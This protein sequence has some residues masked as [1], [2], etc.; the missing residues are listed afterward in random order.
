MLYINTL[1]RIVSGLLLVSH[2]L[3]AEE[4]PNSY[5]SWLENVNIRPIGTLP[6][7]P[8]YTDYLTALASNNPELKGLYH[9]WKSAKETVTI[10]GAWSDP[11]IK[12]GAALLPVVTGQGPQDFRLG[13]VQAIPRPAELKSTLRVQEQ[14]ANAAYAR[15][16]GKLNDLNLALK[17]SFG[18]FYLRS[19]QLSIQNQIMA[20]LI[21]WQEVLLTRYRN[22]AASHPDLIKTQLELLNLEDE[23]KKTEVTLENVKDQLR[24][25]LY[26]DST[27]PLAAPQELHADVLTQINVERDWLSRNPELLLHEANQLSAKYNQQL[28]RS[29]TRPQFVLGLD[30]IFI[31]DSDLV[32]PALNP[33]QDAIAANVGVSLPL[34]RS[35]NKAR[36]AAAYSK[37][38][39]HEANYAA[40][41][42]ALE[43]TMEQAKRGFEDAQ[44]RIELLEDTMIPKS[45]E[46]YEVLETAYTAGNADLLSLLDAVEN[47]L[48]YQFQLEEAKVDLWNADARLN[49]LRGIVK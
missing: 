20:L 35:K 9:Q 46:V 21:N 16:N 47:M 33:G 11:Q 4:D 39:A 27:D 24:I 7:E 44:R 42:K 38:S 22:A 2:T 5:K 34:W 18:E 25:M 8:T 31:G 45:Q 32:N 36:V 49:H 3:L 23:I 17:K 40:Q 30:W 15:L 29:Q 26:L 6:A 41:Q 43:M 28:A 10:A 19:Q 13:I 12:A 48:K 14:E 37:L 1:I